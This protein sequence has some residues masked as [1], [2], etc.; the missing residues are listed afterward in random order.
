MTKLV[1]QYTD[2]ENTWYIV[3]EKNSWAH[4]LNTIAYKA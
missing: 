1:I 2:P 4:T 3:R